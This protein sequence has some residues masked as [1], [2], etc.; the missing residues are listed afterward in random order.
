MGTAVRFR[1]VSFVFFPG[2]V[3]CFDV[4]ALWGVN[5]RRG[6]VQCSTACPSPYCK[7]GYEFVRQVLEGLAA[8]EQ[9]STFHFSQVSILAPGFRF[10]LV[11]VEEDELDRWVIRNLSVRPEASKTGVRAYIRGTERLTSAR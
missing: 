7:A 11:G 6:L 4:W 8:G 10:S 5:G 9:V 1:F 2:S 3:A